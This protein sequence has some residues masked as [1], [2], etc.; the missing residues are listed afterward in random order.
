MTPPTSPEHG[1][2]P[3]GVGYVDLF[4]QHSQAR[5]VEKVLVWNGDLLVT[6]K[7]EWNVFHVPILMPAVGL[8]HVMC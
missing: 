4:L 2:V 6:V 3:T 8:A 5:V 7:R 1:E